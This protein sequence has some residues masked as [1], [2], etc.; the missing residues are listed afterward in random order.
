MCNAGATKKYM[1][2]EGNKALNKRGIF[3]K[4]STPSREDTPPPVLRSSSSSASAR[5]L[6]IKNRGNVNKR[7]V[8]SGRRTSKA[9]TFSRGN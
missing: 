7:K 3:P 1:M 8:A 9:R 5:N 6:G 2:H 4:K